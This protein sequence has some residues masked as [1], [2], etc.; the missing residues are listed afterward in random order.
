MPVYHMIPDPAKFTVSPQHHRGMRTELWTA[1][2]LQ[3]MP[4]GVRVQYVLIT[5]TA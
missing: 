2:Q 5:S 1:R 4:D 3:Q